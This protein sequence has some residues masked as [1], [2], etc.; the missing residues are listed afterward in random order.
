MCGGCAYVC[1]VGYRRVFQEG[2]QLLAGFCLPNTQCQTNT[3]SSYTNLSSPPPPKKQPYRDGPA[4]AGLSEAQKRVV[5]LELRDFV[6]GGVSLEGEAKERY[7]KIQQD[8]AQLSTKFSN[9][10]LDATK[11]SAGVCVWGGNNLGCFLGTEAGK[12][13]CR[14]GRRICVRLCLRIEEGSCLG[15]GGAEA[16]SIPQYTVLTESPSPL[17]PTPPTG[18]QETD[19]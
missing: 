5:E 8:L 12:G 11:V 18:I 1:M 4:W 2:R 13:R 6:L 19:H 9:N 3:L 14:G 10:V 7:N 17:P 16:V 15:L